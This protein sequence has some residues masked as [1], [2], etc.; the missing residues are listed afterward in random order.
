[1][2]LLDIKKITEDILDPISSIYPP[3]EWIRC[4]AGL[5]NLKLIFRNGNLYNVLRSVRF[6][7]P[8]SAASNH[9]KSALDMLIALLDKDI[10]GDNESARILFL[11]NVDEDIDDSSV[12]MNSASVRKKRETLYIKCMFES[13][14]IA[15]GL[16]SD[17]NGLTYYPVNLD[18]GKIQTHGVK[19]ESVMCAISRIN[20]GNLQKQI[21][22]FMIACQ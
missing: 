6:S 12:Q 1:M 2:K 13:V 18:Y 7:L 14:A 17:N 3:F 10:Y 11:K 5:G 19:E 22:M 4:C 21:R 9:W 15:V 20:A 16:C 8:P